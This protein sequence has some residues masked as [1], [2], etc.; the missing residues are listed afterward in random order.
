MLGNIKE[1]ERVYILDRRKRPVLLMGE[2]VEVKPPTTQFGQPIVP[3]N[4]FLPAFTEITVRVNDG[5]MTFGKVPCGKNL[6]D[7]GN[8]WV[9]S[10]DS[11]AM[12]AYI[13]DMK[14]TSM[15]RL[16]NRANDEEIVAACDEMMPTLNP[17]MRRE[18]ERDRL[19]DER[20]G[21][22]ESMLMKILERD[23]AVTPQKD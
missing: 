11:N 14:Q 19:V 16:A 2:V 10:N 4:N 7:M 18:Q 23:Q 5:D 22:I 1:N 13:D 20:F 3:G 15:T 8:G 12:C 6:F 17:N 9:I 21:R